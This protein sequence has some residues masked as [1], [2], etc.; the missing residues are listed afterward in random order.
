MEI[1]IY[2]EGLNYG[3]ECGIHKVIEKIS[4][5]HIENWLRDLRSKIESYNNSGI[6]YMLIVTNL[7]KDVLNILKRELM[8]YISEKGLGLNLEDV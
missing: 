1:D 3:I 2:I 6:K 4:R 7:R 8:G 5:G